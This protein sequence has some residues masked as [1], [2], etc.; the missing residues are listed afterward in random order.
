MTTQQGYLAWYDATVHVAHR[1]AARLC[2]ED[3]GTVEDLVQEAYLTVLR[4]ARDG[5]VLEATRGLITTVLRSRFLDSVRSAS[6][7]ERRLR[8]AWT[9][10]DSADSPL[11][12]TLGLPPRERAALVLRYAEGMS[13]PDVAGELGISLHAAE[14]LLARAK[15]RAWKEKHHHG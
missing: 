13:V 5:N 3:T 10:P 14:S 2:G 15:A 6:G 4:Q 9:S 7:E 8:L 12:P 1:Y 11:D